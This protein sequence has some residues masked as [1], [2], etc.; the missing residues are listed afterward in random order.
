M[1]IEGKCDFAPGPWEAV[2]IEEGLF[3]IHSPKGE[4]HNPVPV[5]VLDHHRDGDEPTRT[6]RTPA[7]AYLIASAPEM[8]EALKGIADADQKEWDESLRSA[9]DFKRWAQSLANHV[10]NKARVP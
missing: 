4:R 8:Y 3:H 9:E 6:I 5:A 1:S 7:N 2:Q 10:V